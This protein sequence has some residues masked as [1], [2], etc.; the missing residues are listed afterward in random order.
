[1]GISLK[2]AKYFITCNGQYYLNKEFFQ[3]D[4]I[5]QNLKM[6]ELNTTYNKEVQ[7]SLFNE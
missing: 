2:R 6:L 3:K 1:M 5:M 4:F 7:L